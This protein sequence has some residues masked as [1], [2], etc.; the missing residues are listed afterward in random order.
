MIKFQCIFF[1]FFLYFFFLVH[2][3]MTKT[4][5]KIIRYI[6]QYISVD[7]QCIF[8]CTFFLLYILLFFQ[9]SGQEFRISFLHMSRMI[10]FFFS[11]RLLISGLDV[12]NIFSFVSEFRFLTKM[13]VT[14]SVKDNIFYIFLYLNMTKHK[15]VD[16]FSVVISAH[17]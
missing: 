17:K 13:I 10:F 12:C 2:E 7:K 11:K 14:T 3:A 5:N 16:L 15:N 6:Y 9:Y 4:V 1:L 8:F